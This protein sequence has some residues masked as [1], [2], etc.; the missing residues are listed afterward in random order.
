[1]SVE[2][3]MLAASSSGG[4]DPGFSRDELLLWCMGDRSD[5]DIASDA[6][7]LARAHGKRKSSA[8][9]EPVA[10]MA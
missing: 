8:T 1:M 7:S 4:N 10:S 2:S 6:F 9:A 5:E 3:G